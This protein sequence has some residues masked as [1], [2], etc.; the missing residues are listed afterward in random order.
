MYLS[1]KR[2]LKT[3]CLI[4]IYVFTKMTLEEDDTLAY[5]RSAHGPCL[6]RSV[7]RS[8]PFTQKLVA[9]QQQGQPKH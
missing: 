2:R 5:P 8:T 1:A 3:T 6:G 9:E 7:D 4:K